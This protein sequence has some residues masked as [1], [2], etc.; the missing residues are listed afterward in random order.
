MAE[1][2]KDALA[3]F[4]A[5]VEAWGVKDRLFV[6]FQSE[7]KAKQLVPP[8]TQKSHEQMRTPCPEVHAEEPPADVI[9]RPSW[10]VVH[11]VRERTDFG[12]SAAVA[13]DGDKG[14]H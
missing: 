2:K 4:D 3:A 10:L 7:R 14:S 1:T 8:V 9:G 6:L 12:I 11:S 13:C 5:F